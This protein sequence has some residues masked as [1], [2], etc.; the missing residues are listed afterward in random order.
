VPPDG[1]SLHDTQAR[2]YEWA[3]GASPVLP[4]EARRLIAVPA[5]A[6]PVDRVGVYARMYAERIAQA[7]SDVFPRLASFLG[8]D[9]FR[10]LVAEYLRER[11]PAHPLLQRAGSHL[12]GILAVKGGKGSEWLSE[13]ARLEWARFYA[14]D[15]PDS[16]PLRGGHL[17]GLDPVSLVALPLRLVA[18]H[19]IVECDFAVDSAWRAIRSGTLRRPPRRLVRP[20]ALL[21]W[22][23]GVAVL[24]RRLSAFELRVA[25]VAQEGGTLGDAC[26]LAAR[27]THGAGAAARKVFAAAGR[28]VSEGILARP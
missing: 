9:A 2:F 14:V 12:P 11:P 13:L 17:R 18:A 7:L 24:H 6:S 8:P 22:R 5:G 10:L 27:D 3:T 1:D 25:R 21:V 23:R 19:G 15:A 4:D 26:D 16:E 20:R 28:F